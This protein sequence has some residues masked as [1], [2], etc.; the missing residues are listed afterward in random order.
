MTILFSEGLS[1][2]ALN[3]ARSA[4][5]AYGISHNGILIGK[6]VTII[7]F[8]KGVFNLRPPQPKY[9]KTWDASLVLTYL[10]KLSPIK[11]ISFKDLTLKL[12]MLIALTTASR[13]QSL[14][15]LTIRN[16]EKK[17]SSFVLYFN[18]L[19]KQSRPGWSQ[20]CIELF[21]YPIDR[22]ICVY[23]VLKEYL[24]RSAR[25][26]KDCDSLFISYIKPYKAVSRDTISRWLKTVMLR[27][28]IDIKQFSSHSVRSAS[29][30]KAS[31]NTVAVEK[32][33]KVAG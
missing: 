23:F 2:S 27:S 12:V 25:Y 5:S 1:Y 18:G 26:R 16:I 21:A 29:V 32:I 6:N 31:I 3:T 10:K 14:N 4:L 28:G 20:D 13:S 8:L 17:R 30:S 11:Y 33:L 7:R 9:W 24:Q 22:R 19:L 15:L